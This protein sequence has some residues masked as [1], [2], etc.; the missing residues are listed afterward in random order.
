LYSTTLLMR[1]AIL[2]GDDEDK[3]F[4]KK[5]NLSSLNLRKH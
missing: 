4:T 5:I 3:W 1:D 2:R